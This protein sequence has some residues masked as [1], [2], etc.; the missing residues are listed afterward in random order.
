MATTAPNIPLV[1]TTAPDEQGVRLEYRLKYKDGTY[2]ASKVSS[3]LQPGGT[4]V[5]ESRVELFQSS[6]IIVEDTRKRP[7]VAVTMRA[8]PSEA[9]LSVSDELELWCKISGI[10]CSQETTSGSI[11]LT[12]DA[13][14]WIM[15]DWSSQTRPASWDSWTPDEGNI[16]VRFSGSKTEHSAGTV[17]AEEAVIPFV[18]TREEITVSAT[19]GRATISPAP[20][21][22]GSE[23]EISFSGYEWGTVVTLVANDPDECYTFDRWEYMGSDEDPHGI[24]GSTSS[25]VTLTALPNYKP[26]EGYSY[27]A[28]RTSYR[29]V[30]KRK[31][32]TLTVAVSPQGAA[33]APAPEVSDCGSSWQ[34]IAPAPYDSCDYRFDHWS[35]E[36]TDR[37]HSE[38]SPTSDITLTA[39]YT[40]IE[41]R[42]SVLVSGNGAGGYSVSPQQSTYHK[43]DEVY[44][45]V[46]PSAPCSYVDHVSG[47][48]RMSDG[49]YKV[50][51]D[52]CSSYHTK[53]VYIYFYKYSYRVTT[54]VSP[55]GSG[56]V[57]PSSESNVPCGE[58]R[59]FTAVPATC[60]RFLRWSTG[61]TDPELRVL[62]NSNKSLVA[63]F[64]MLPLDHR[65]LHGRST[66]QLLFTRSG[67]NLLWAGCHGQTEA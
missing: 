48:A 49:R 30:Y 31:Q 34:P 51:M 54:S 33:Q 42:L 41:H 17:T 43:G 10:S 64:E 67:G 29:A 65:L 61:S 38:M 5:L 15:A 26:G 2:S 63:Y 59:T 56:T 44:I 16:E 1:W 20:L 19:Y 24:N 57:R 27:Q 23:S 11:T 4:R 40:R 62:V 32:V 47:A 52:D 14:R 55:E 6:E 13:S 39:I 9:A 66:G 21:P 36:E 46:T 25:T 8:D 18:K 3:C 22:P 28:R 37:R 45:T 50:T 58:Y 7:K 35:D 53:Y 12:F 60:S